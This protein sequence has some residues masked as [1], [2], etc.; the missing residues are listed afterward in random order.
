MQW[1]GA[2]LLWPESAFLPCCG[3]SD[4]RCPYRVPFG[5]YLYHTKDLWDS[6]AIDLRLIELPARQVTAGAQGHIVVVEKAQ[7][8]KVIL[9]DAPQG[10]QKSCLVI[11]DPEF[12]VEATAIGDLEQSHR[13]VIGVK[14]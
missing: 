11:L 5:E 9:V 4:C 14:D 7:S 13:V 2:A 10:E 1:L 3:A 6:Q 8:V 12:L